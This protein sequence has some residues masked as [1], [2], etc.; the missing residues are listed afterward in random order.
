MTSFC[1]FHPFFFCKLCRVS[2]FAPNIS[3]IN[4]SPK[5]CAYSFK[6][7]KRISLFGLRLTMT[8]PRARAARHKGQLNFENERE[9]FCLLLLPLP[10]PLFPFKK[11]SPSTPKFLFKPPFLMTTP[12]KKKSARSS[13]PTATA[14]TPCRK[15]C[16]CSTRS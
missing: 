10:Q 16:A 1:C 3:L 7:L 12:L 6:P 5:V 15:R 13:S 11:K 9:F 4:K 14:P 8:E 2:A